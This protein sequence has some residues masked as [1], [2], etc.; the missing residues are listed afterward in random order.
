MQM[1]PA[2]IQEENCTGMY[3]KR[4]RNRNGNIVV[5]Q[6]ALMIHKSSLCSLFPVESTNNIKIKMTC[7]RV[8][9]DGCIWEG[10]LLMNA[11]MLALSFSQ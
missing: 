10:I 9:R 3:L 1:L 4:L 5:N 11:R 2:K 8:I 6:T 7:H